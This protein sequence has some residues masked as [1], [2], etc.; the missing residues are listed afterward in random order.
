MRLQAATRTNGLRDARAA[1]SLRF[2]EKLS[3]YLN[4]DFTRCFHRLDCI[5]YGMLLENR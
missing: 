4:S 2:F 5:E 1:G 3:R